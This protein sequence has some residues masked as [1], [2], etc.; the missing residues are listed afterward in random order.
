MKT[1]QSA[2]LKTALKKRTAAKKAG[3]YVGSKKIKSALVKKGYSN[4]SAGAI[5]G[6]IA[7]KKYGNKGVAA[8]AAYGK[9]NKNK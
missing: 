3:T 6:S 1:K 4:E 7:R 8:L 2:A 9:K 5:V